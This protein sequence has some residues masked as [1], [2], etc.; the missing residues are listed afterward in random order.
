[1]S[2]QTIGMII[3]MVVLAFILQITACK[4]YFY[5]KNRNRRTQE[6]ENQINTYAV[7]RP[8]PDPPSA[9][10]YEEVKNP[11]LRTE[12]GPTPQITIPMYNARYIEHTN[13]NTSRPRNNQASSQPAM[14]SSSQGD[15]EFSFVNAPESEYIPMKS[16]QFRSAF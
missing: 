4:A 7:N 13:A 3:G 16:V 14:A 5:W 1:M 9:L 6:E 15:Y 2:P 8:L 10:L 11:L 12:A